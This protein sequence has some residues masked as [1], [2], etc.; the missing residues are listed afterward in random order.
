MYTKFDRYLVLP[1][2]LAKEAQSLYTLRGRLVSLDASEESG[3]LKTT[4]M[5]GSNSSRRIS[6]NSSSRLMGLTTSPS[7]LSSWSH[8]FFLCLCSCLGKFQFISLHAQI[9]MRSAVSLLS[10]TVQYL[11]SNFKSLTD[12]WSN[13][14]RNVVRSE[15]GKHQWN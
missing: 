1:R 15:L 5:I 2:L 4:C 3:R 12:G 11:V 13:R 14:T 7:R 6:C 10:N 9:L 8:M